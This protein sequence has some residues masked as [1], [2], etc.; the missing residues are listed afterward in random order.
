M[1]TSC[2]MVVALEGEKRMNRL[3]RGRVVGG[4]T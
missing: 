4:D 3:Q 1:G 2:T